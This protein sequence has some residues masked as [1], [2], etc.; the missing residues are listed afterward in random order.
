VSLGPGLL[1]GKAAVVTGASRG[2]GRAIAHRFAR[3]GARVLAV[4]RSAPAGDLPDG[5][6]HMRADVADPRG[7]T[8]V[9]TAAP[10]L[11]G[12]L[13]VLVNNAAAE[14]E[15][16]V[17][18]TSV[19]D[20]DTVMAVNV[21]SVFLLARHAMPHLRASRGSIQNIASIDGLWAEPRL[22]AY[23]ASKGAVL[24]LTR[25]LAV[26]HGPDGVRCNSI[27]PSYVLT[28]MLERFYDAQPD[29]NA[30]RAG[31]ASLHA[32]RRLSTPDEVAA[33]AAWISSDEAGFATGQSF[34]LDGGA[35]AG[36]SVDLARL[37]PSGGA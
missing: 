15:G 30:A 26:D 34:V 10:D 9:V 19:L 14:V 35:T 31:A 17:E 4:S 33:L 5:V 29:P 3:E 25:A 7:A 28:E 2:I 6:Q 11:L 13:E 12:R 37:G 36:R 22:A 21:R 23:C 18:E 32:L 16:T 1:A 8:R 27:S 20:W 24:A